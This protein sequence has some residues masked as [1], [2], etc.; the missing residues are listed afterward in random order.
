M[1]G[2]TLYIAPES[3]KYLHGAALRHVYLCLTGQD[4]V[5]LLE[6]TLRGTLKIGLDRKGA[7]PVW[8]FHGSALDLLNRDLLQRPPAVPPPSI[9][10]ASKTCPPPPV[11][12]EDPYRRHAIHDRNGDLAHEEKLEARERVL[13]VAALTPVEWKTHRHKSL[14]DI[15]SYLGPTRLRKVLGQ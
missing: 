4:G 13:L 3:L 2:Y 1:T 7:Q 15:K 14:D 12:K 5:G 9:A 10:A 8:C 6:E 11:V